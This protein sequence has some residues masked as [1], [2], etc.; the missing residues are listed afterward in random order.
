MFQI[1]L[2]LDEDVTV[3]L[4]KVLRERG[5]DVYH[6]N[7]VERIRMSDLE[8]LD[9][10]VGQKRAIL[11]HNIR[12]YIKLSKTYQ[13]QGKNHCGII[14][15]DQLPFGE[16]LKRTLRFLSSYPNDSLKNCFIWLHD[17]K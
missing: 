3:L 2:Y 13:A 16:L 11:T 10:A 8:Q 9:Y 4:A 15:S 5:Y 7:E 1:S 6:V 12:D 17:Y 14:V